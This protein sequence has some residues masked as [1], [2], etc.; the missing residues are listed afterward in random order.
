MKTAESIAASKNEN[1]LR[2]ARV[3]L[4]IAADKLGKALD[5]G[6]PHEKAEEI[7]FLRRQTTGLADR[8]RRMDRRRG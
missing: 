1:A 6:L 2:G 7:A 4:C 3:H 8:L 5:Q